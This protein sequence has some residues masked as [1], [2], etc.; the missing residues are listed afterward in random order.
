MP[1]GAR[2]SN[3][4]HERITNQSG[5]VCQLAG[6]LQILQSSCSQAKS[7]E[8]AASITV[9]LCHVYFILLACKTPPLCTTF[10]ALW[11]AALEEL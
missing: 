5:T 4:H 11:P 7:A 8:S 3:T 10:L 2:A 9:M 6:C 1:A